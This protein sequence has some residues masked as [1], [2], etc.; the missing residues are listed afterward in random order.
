MFI[1]TRALGFWYGGDERHEITTAKKFGEKQSS[2]TLGF[3]VGD[4][5][6]TRSQYACLAAPLS[7]HS[8]TVAAH[9]H[10]LIKS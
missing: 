9:I 10:R 1:H 8:A 5:M 6:Q 4:P 2:V 3:R 7:Q